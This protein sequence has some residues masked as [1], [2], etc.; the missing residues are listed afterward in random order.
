[1]DLSKDLLL[2][3]AGG[4]VT[5]IVTIAINKLQSRGPSVKWRILPP[6][7]FPSQQLTAFNVAIENIGAKSAKNVRA[8]V[9]LPDNAIVESFEIQVSEEAM[10]Y[11]SH[12]E[13][14][15][16]EVFFPYFGK[17][18]EC[19]IG[20]LSKGVNVSQIHVSII[21][22]EDVI[23][24]AKEPHSSTT[25]YG[26]I[27][28]LIVHSFSW[29]FVLI[30]A[31][32]LLIWAGLV[33]QRRDNYAQQMDIAEV[34]LQG[35]QFDKAITEYQ[36]IP[37]RWWFPTS[38]R[39]FYKMAIAFAGKGEFDKSLFFLGKLKQSDSALFQFA[40]T[41]TVFD[42]IRS[43]PKFIEVTTEEK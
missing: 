2:L 35:N 22:D 18:L 17:G 38:P 5:F 21:G 15:H 30:V 31:A 12:S 19:I 36:K 32:L 14:N 6:V 42:S 7:F 20:V 28:G 11:E 27:L 1:M 29:T 26:R 13:K 39:L 41:N 37:E 25:V 16:V 34:Y 4:L 24:K 33:T 10:K 40:I 8:V 9:I 43:S 23:G 3:P